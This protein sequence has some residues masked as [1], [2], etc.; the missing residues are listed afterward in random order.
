MEMFTKP[1]NRQPITVP[2]EAGRV[3]H[4]LGVRHKLTDKQTDG[5]IYLFDSEFGPG[6]GN[7]L[8]V[9]RYEDELGYVLEGA[10][11]VRLGD[12]ELEVTTGGI[13]YLPKNIPH[14]LR[15]PLTTPSRY[16]FAAIPGGFIE[17]WFEAVEAAAEAGG[18]DDTAYRELALKYGI[19]WLE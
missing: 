8:H 1:E 6:V 19:E 12:Q 7:K 5:A 18:L 4:V 13:A 16:L 2:P 15:N 14:A 9:H 17:H 3:L 11:V 10:L